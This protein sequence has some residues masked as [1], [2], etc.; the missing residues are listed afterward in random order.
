MD[1]TIDYGSV[2]LGTLGVAVIDGRLV[3]VG[4]FD[5]STG[6]NSAEALDP[7]VG[8]WHMV[9]LWRYLNV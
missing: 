5:G 4:G 2:D 7:R 8:E 1:A 6:L 3:A 9:R